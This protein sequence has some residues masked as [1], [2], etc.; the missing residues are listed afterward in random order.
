M[1]A[2]FPVRSGKFTFENEWADWWRKRGWLEIN[3]LNTTD[4]FDYT[5]M[6][7]S[8]FLFYYQLRR[9]A[10]NMIFSEYIRTH[11]NKPPHDFLRMQQYMQESP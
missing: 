11:C 1:S 10:W 4:L 2:H 7:Y 9:T 6:F 8:N 5:F 3:K